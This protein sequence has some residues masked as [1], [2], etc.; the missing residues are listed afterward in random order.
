M[1]LNSYEWMG[2]KNEKDGSSGEWVRRRKY[3]NGSGERQLTL[4]GI[5]GI[6][7][8]PNSVEIF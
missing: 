1:I 5:R 3:G 7:G 2:W 6:V 8:K 4:R